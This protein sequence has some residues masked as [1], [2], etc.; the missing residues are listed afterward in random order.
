MN[1]KV[2]SLFSGVGGIDIAFHDAGFETIFMNEIDNDAVRT[3]KENFNNDVVVQEDIMEID[4]QDF[5][6]HNVLVAGFPCQPFSVAG[7]RQSFN[8]PRGSFIFKIFQIVDCHRPEVIFL[9][10]VKNLLTINNGEDFDKILE[11][12]TNLGYF[13]TYKVMNSKEYSS[14]PQNRERIYIVCFKHE[15]NFKKFVWPSK[16]KRRDTISNIVSEFDDN[17]SYTYD[18]YPKIFE[19]LAEISDP[20]LETTYQWRRQYLRANKSGEFPTLTANMG[21][22]GHNVPLIKQD[23]KWRK[24]SPREAFDLQG[25]PKKFK[26][27]DGISNSALYK[28]AGNSV[29]VPVI[30]KIAK[31]IKIALL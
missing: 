17:F 3:L 22:G 5:P 10:N 24:I 19:H 23:N 18:K 14:I 25:F 28:Q 8:D 4:E 7:N 6:K 27:P 31:Q 26:F 13:I 11:M 12:L 30:K 20:D 2:V 15:D 21:T 16:S 29:S 1:N 9:E